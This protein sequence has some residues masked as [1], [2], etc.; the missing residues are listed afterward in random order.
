MHS[1]HTHGSI[2]LCGVSKDVYGELYVSSLPLSYLHTSRTLGRQ[3]LMKERGALTAVAA[4]VGFYCESPPEGHDGITCQCQ[5]KQP[6][7][8]TQCKPQPTSEALARCHC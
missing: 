5:S 6:T 3:N 7:P 8:R 1:E 4:S 2:C